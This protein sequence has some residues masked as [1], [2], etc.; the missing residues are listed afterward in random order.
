MH[1]NIRYSKVKHLIACIPAE[2]GHFK[3][4]M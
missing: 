1:Q 4:S 3:N 2:G